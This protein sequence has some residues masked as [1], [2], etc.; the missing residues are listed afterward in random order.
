MITPGPIG[1]TVARLV[2][3]ADVIRARLRITHET[4]DARP[5]RLQHID[6]CDPD[7]SARDL[8]GNCAIAMGY[9]WDAS[10]TSKANR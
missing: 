3:V 4:Q 10:G 5:I 8:R 9:L 1:V 2:D 6:N 7:A